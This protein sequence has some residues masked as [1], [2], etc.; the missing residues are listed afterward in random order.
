MAK[1]ELTKFF[2]ERLHKAGPRVQVCSI[3]IQEGDFLC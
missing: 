2:K 3:H 1:T